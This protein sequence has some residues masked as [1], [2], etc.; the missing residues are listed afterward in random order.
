MTNKSKANVKQEQG[1]DKVNEQL[2]FC[3]HTPILLC[4]NYT[5]YFSGTSVLHSVKYP[6]ICFFL[7]SSKRV[8][9]TNFL[10]FLSTLEPWNGWEM[11]INQATL[12]FKKQRQKRKQALS[13]ANGSMQMQM[14]GSDSNGV[15][16]VGSS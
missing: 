10:P 1:N 15:V 6:F 2:L 3:I 13:S 8:S 12:Y 14:R 7:S 11:G 4:N 9:C 16:W 5:K